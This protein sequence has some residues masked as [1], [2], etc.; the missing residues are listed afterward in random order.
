MQVELLTKTSKVTKTL[1][2]EAWKENVPDS[3]QQ[4]PK[5][6]TF[7]LELVKCKDENVPESDQQ[8]RKPPSFRYN[9]LDFNKRSSVIRNCAENIK[10]YDIA[11][12][13]LQCCP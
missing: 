12:T 7:R 6:P 1:N 9:M 4:V 11:L 3:E 2:V 8:G 13:V 5:C 10:L